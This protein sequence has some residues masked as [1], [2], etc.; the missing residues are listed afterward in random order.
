[1]FWLWLEG[2]VGDSLTPVP[3]CHGAEEMGQGVAMP[4]S[5]DGAHVPSDIQL[6]RQFSRKALM[7]LLTCQF[8]PI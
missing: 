1:M 6:T 3:L 5:V 2:Q 4:S 7:D 8:P